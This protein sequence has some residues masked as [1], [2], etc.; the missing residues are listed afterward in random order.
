MELQRMEGQAEVISLL[1]PEGSP[2]CQLPP[3]S[4]Q[5][6]AAKDIQKTLEF[7]K[8]RDPPLFDPTMDLTDLFVNLLGILR[9]KVK[10]SH[11]SI[12]RIQG[13]GAEDGVQY[14]PRASGTHVCACMHVC[15][16][17][18]ACVHVCV[19]MRACSRC[20]NDKQRIWCVWVGPR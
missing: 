18:C 6:I 20:R 11:D 14:K 17:V 2:Q 12:A 19:S 4:Q 8:P 10:S 1:T 16:H 15:A 9:D 13:I 3:T 5:R 7:V